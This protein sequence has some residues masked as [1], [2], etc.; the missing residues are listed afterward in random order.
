MYRIFGAAHAP[1]SS[2][3]FE[4]NSKVRSRAVLEICLTQQPVS[5]ACLFGNGREMRMEEITPG[6][7]QTDI[8]PGKNAEIV[9]VEWIAEQAL[10]LLFCDPEGTVG[11]RA[12][13]R[14][15]E[16]AVELVSK[17]RR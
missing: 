8:L 9:A 3:P 15:E 11:Q 12:L 2:M 14:D 5:S 7:S 4:Y 1:K 16:S 10:D 6:S 17:G 13:Y